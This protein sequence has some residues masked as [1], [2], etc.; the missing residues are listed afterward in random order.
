MSTF[1]IPANHC[2]AH[3]NFDLLKQHI[4]R[5]LWALLTRLI[6]KLQRIS[7]SIE[8]MSTSNKQSFNKSI[9][10]H[11]S[12][13]LFHYTK[14]LIFRVIFVN[15]IFRIFCLLPCAVFFA[16]VV[17]HIFHDLAIYRGCQSSFKSLFCN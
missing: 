12:T 17:C 13:K 2:G 11:F 15:E 1:E 8:I 14:M 6:T 10:R 9:F 5:L 4:S 3:K 7:I 16:A